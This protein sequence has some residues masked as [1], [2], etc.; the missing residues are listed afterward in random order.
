MLG[1]KSALATLTALLA[2][3][4]LTQA[5]ADDPCGIKSDCIFNGKS[6]GSLCADVKDIDK[7]LESVCYLDVCFCGFKMTG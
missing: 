7:S 3:S 1:F 2:I 6:C 4:T 5:I